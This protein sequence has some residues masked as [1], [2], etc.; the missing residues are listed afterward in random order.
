MSWEAR[1]GRGKYYTR[2]YRLDGR[3]VREYVGSGP[4]AER[5]AEADRQKRLAKRDALA[6]KRRKKE[7]AKLLADR[8]SQLRRRIHLLAHVALVAAGY[9]QHHRGE[10][11]KKRHE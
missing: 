1:K 9:R 10:W 11:R 8:V 6:A 5:A 4:A 7:A 2:S 3:V